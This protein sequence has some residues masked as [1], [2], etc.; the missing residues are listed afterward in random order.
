MM[1]SSPFSTMRRWT[2]L[3]PPELKSALS[4][5]EQLLVA[6]GRLVAEGKTEFSAEQ[7]VA[8]AFH[9]FP[10]EFHLRGY[11][12]Y[13][14]SN[15]VLTKLMGKSAPLVVRGWIAKTGTKKYRLTRT[16]LEEF[17]AIEGG[18]HSSAFARLDQRKEEEI[19]TLLALPAFELFKSGEPDQITFHQFCR[20]VGLAAGDKWQAVEGKLS[21]ART[22]V[23]EAQ[24]IGESGR[25]L[26]VFLRGKNIEY[27]AEDLQTLPAVL[28]HMEQR[29]KPQMQEW[30]RN[31]AG[32]V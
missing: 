12:N 13:P 24:K 26:R 31:A 2:L 9:V 14:D 6:A 1:P 19:G 25:G 4:R 28:K 11:K 27:E 16:G 8:S 29:F 18:E 10:E 3:E 30:K 20:F 22:L 32:S 21:Q 7:L 23:E 17:R 5:V 15:R